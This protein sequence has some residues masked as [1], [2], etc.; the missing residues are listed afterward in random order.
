MGKAVFMDRD[1]TINKEVNYLYNQ[2]DFVFIAG[3][4]EAIKI[5]HELGYH[6]FVITNQAGV[7]KGY[8]TEADVKILHQYIDESL[9]VEDTYVDAYYYCPHHPEGKVEGYKGE[10]NCRKPHIGMIEQAL[11]DFDI[12]L[13]ESI[14]VGDKEIDMQTGKNVGIGKSILVRS[15]HPVEEGKT[16]ANAIYANICDFARSLK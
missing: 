6:V 12:D 2:N 7:A 10:C 1:G 9:A 16:L 14:I 5:F 11:K 13:S 4:V 3:A 8:Y 15:G